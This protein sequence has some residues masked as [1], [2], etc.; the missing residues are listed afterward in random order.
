MSS[1][2][3]GGTV[4]TYNVFGLPFL[5]PIYGEAGR[6][7]HLME[8]RAIANPLLIIAVLVVQ[9]IPLVLFPAQSFAPTTQEWWLPVL[10]AVMVVVADVYLIVLRSPAPWPWYLLSFAQGFNI[11]SRLMMV[12]PH[13]ATLVGKVWV[14][15]PLYVVLSVISIL[16]SAVILWYTELPDVRMG[17]LRG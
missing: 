4:T 9:L 6:R 10:L 12:W 8:R 2:L 5:G 15:N 1:G 11:I 14:F 13:S 17:L 7:N 16:M 3:T